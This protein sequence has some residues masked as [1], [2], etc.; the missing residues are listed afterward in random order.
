MR[1]KTFS[2]I[3]FLVFGSLF[4]QWGFAVGKNPR[5]TP[6]MAAE[7]KHFFG[8]R[9]YIDTHNHIVGKL[10]PRSGS[11]PDYEGAAG[12]ALKAMNRFGIKKML[13]MPPPFPLNPPHTYDIEDLIETVSRHANR[14]GFLGGGG[15]LNV[16]IQEAV[17]AGSTSE[18]L[19][20]RFKKRALDIL[21]K[22]ALGFGEMS[23]EHFSLGKKHHHQSAPPDHLLFLLLADIAAEHNVPI[24]IHMEAVPEKMPLPTGLSSPPNP[25]ILTPNIKAFERLL[26][27]NKKAK[28]IWAHVGWDNTGR[29]T[30]AL[31][32]GM[33]KRH[34]NL[35][36]SFKISPRD[37]VSGTR[38]IERGIGLKREWLRL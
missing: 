26:A 29:R 6:V 32:S 30:A 21:S 19:R 28:I 38:P 25:S 23:A 36:M 5:V 35:Y 22:R 3:G 31:V 27:H 13:I 34:A 11:S 4:L 16:M 12:V 33:L 37:S 14:F 7:R 8:S 20:Q 2:I 18:D 10:G 15:T 9:T 17:A 1:I 24:D